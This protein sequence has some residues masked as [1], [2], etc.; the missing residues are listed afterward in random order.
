MVKQGS[1]ASSSRI[2]KVRNLRQHNRKLPTKVISGQQMTEFMQ[3]RYYLMQGNQQVDV[4]Q[5]TMQRWLSIWLEQGEIS[6]SWNFN[7]FN[8]ATL[9]AIANQ[10]PWQFYY[11]VDQNFAS[12]RSFIKKELPAVPLQKR[13]QVVFEDDVWVDQLAQQL[14]LN[15][16]LSSF[17]DD[18]E[19][20]AKI[21]EE[22]IMELA[23]GLKKDE[24][25]NW[26]N[27]RVVYST[28]V[29]KDTQ[30]LDAE[31][32]QWLAALQMIVIA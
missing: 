32:E 21:T 8:Q 22:Q 11:L 15:W 9:G 3:V 28:I 29:F 5:Q 1:F 24:T 7:Q 4:T 6:T 23:R 2:K 26:H 12:F 25:I 20:L 13:I 14:S 18:P 30:N 10:V 31:T 19:R 27:V 16:F 17:A